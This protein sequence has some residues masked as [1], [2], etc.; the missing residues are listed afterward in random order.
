MTI[1]S[2]SFTVLGT[3]AAKGNM[4]AFPFTKKDGKLGA[5]V[6]EGTKSSKGWATSVR[7]AAQQQ[8]DGLFFEDGPIRLTVAIFLPRPKSLPRRVTAHIKKPDCSKLLRNIEDALTGTLWRDDAQIVRLAVA[9]GYAITQ[10]HVRITV[11][12]DAP[13]EEAITDQDLFQGLQEVSP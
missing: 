10:P 13:V 2:V 11:S 1:R 6:T 12:D 7:A 4:K 8:C 9:K 3:A 5:A